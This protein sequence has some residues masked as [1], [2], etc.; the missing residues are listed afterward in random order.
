[1]NPYGFILRWLDRR[2]ERVVAE[3]IQVVEVGLSAVD[4]R[5]GLV[6]QCVAADSQAGSVAL[7]SALSRIAR[8][9][10]SILHEIEPQRQ[11]ASKTGPGPQKTPLFEY[12][13]G[14]FIFSVPVTIDAIRFRGLPSFGPGGYTG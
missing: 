8:A 9:E 7:V 11:Q 4:G 5:I 2:V 14:R 13:D 1:M 3:R 10:A 6:A 12:K